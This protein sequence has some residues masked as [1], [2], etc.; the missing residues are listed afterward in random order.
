MPY[1]TFDRLNDIDEG[2]PAIVPGELNYLVSELAVKYVETKGLSYQ[3]LNDVSGALTE[4]LAEFR[5]RVVV[6]YEENKLRTGVDPYE[7]L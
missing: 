5:R 2:S 6:P 7:N 1:I 4:A 3:T